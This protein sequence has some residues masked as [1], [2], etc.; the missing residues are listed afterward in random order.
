M[1]EEL[2]RTQAWF[3][4]RCGR[5]TA[6]RFADVMARN[7]RTGEPLKACHDLIWQVVVERM[8]GQPV[9]GAQGVALQWG[10]DCEPYA[11]SAYELET[12][13]VV[14]ETGLILH[15]VF[16]FSG[17]SPDGLIGDDGILELKAPKSSAVHLQRFIDGVPEEYRAQIMGQLWCSGRKWADFCSYD[18]R[19][20][21][22]FQ[23]LRIRVERDEE[24]IERL[25]VA[26]LQA[27]VAAQELQARLERIAA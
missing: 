7:K 11:R 5:F 24:Y 17:A 14:V 25:Q 26:V 10:T 18:P 13:N 16:T 19:Q 21:E 4:D 23:L 20:K 2:Q 6:S 27:E 8:T 12:G 3:T 1:T 15:P 9:E 22:K